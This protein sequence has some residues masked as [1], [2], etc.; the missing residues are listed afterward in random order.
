MIY[1]DDPYINVVIGQLKNDVRVLME[2]ECYTGAVKLIY[3]GI[4]IMAWLD[5][6]KMKIQSVSDAKQVE[7]FRKWVSNYIVDPNG[8]ELDKLLWES[9]NAILHTHTAYS[10]K[11]RRG[12]SDILPLGFS[13]R[14]RPPVKCDDKLCM[15]DIPWLADCYSKGVD[16]F[17]V[18]IFE[19]RLKRGIAEERLKEMLHFYPV[20]DAHSASGTPV[21]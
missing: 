15:V 11:M 10:R 4:D 19:N 2:N 6:P 17:M 8:V 13:V 5:M 16:K 1:S 12:N 21:A 9:R 7:Y 18:N 20:D 14:M 3:S